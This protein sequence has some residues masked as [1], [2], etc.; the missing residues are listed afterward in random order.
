[1][2]DGRWSGF[3]VIERVAG[4]SS[5]NNA[6]DAGVDKPRP[7]IWRRLFGDDLLGDP[8]DQRRQRLCATTTGRPEPVWRLT[9]FYLVL[10]SFHGVSPGI[11]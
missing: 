8:S 7:F 5:M 4:Q 2:V 6:T 3:A 10:P 11:T 1:M 9:G